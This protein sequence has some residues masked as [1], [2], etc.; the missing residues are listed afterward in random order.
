MFINE[1]ITQWK[2][3]PLFHNVWGIFIFIAATATKGAKR[4]HTPRIY[5]TTILIYTCNITL[6]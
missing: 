2:L 5:A 6:F 4:S 1:I 3:V